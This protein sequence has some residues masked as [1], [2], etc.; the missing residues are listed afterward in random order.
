MIWLTLSLLP[1]LPIVPRVHSGSVEPEMEEL[2]YASYDHEMVYLIGIP[3]HYL[4]VT[5]PQNGPETQKFRP[6]LIL[7]NFALIVLNLLAVVYTIQTG[8]PRFSLRTLFV[9]TFAIGLV[10]VIG[11]GITAS[12]SVYLF[13]GFTYL[14]FFLPVIAATLI[15]FN[16]NRK[17]SLS[18]DE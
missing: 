5:R 8:M 12:N 3:F 17:T 7:P 4:E 1:N 10:I 2:R 15:F 11:R 13:Y 18:T 16:R 14:I 9:L 6:W